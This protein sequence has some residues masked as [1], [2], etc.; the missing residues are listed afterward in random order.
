MDGFRTCVRLKTR[1]D[2][3][4][5]PEHWDI[6]REPLPPLAEG[7]VL[8]AARFLSVS[9]S[10][11]SQ[12]EAGGA[13]LPPVPLGQVVRSRGVGVVVESRAAEFAPG[14]TVEGPLGSQSHWTGRAAGL[15]KVDPAVPLTR[16]LGVLGMTGLTAYFGMLD[17]CRPREG[18]AVLVSAAAGAVGSV[19]GQIAKLQG[20]RVI[21]VAGG[22]AKCAHVV[23]DLGFDACIDYRAEDVGARLAGLAP[24]GLGVYFD[25]VG[26]EILDA[27]L[28][29]LRLGARIA[30]CG[31]ISGYNEPA[32]IKGPR[33]YLKLLE[34]RSRMEG[35]SVYDFVARHDEGRAALAAWLEGG[36]IRSSEHVEHGLER[37]PEV[38]R[39]LFGGPQIGKLVL[40]VEPA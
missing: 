13:Y 24:E 25:N 6:V 9:P 15:V 14:D 17:V 19:A 40:E 37:F 11:R 4:P 10:L 31:G 35:F 34:M 2:G 20:A 36:A 33:N 16:Y 39:M 27:A 7:E 23:G 32:A 28:M 29:N 3:L 12:M 30:I 22:A 26:G 5:G 1:P 18:E 21:G 38:L 8:V